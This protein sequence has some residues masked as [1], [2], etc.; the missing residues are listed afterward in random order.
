MKDFFPKY[1][2][3]VDPNE[4]FDFAGLFKNLITEC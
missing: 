4:L 3:N 1:L 2:K